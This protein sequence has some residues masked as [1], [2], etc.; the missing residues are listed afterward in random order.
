MALVR[1]NFLKYPGLFWMLL[2]FLACNALF[3]VYSSGEGKITV[4]F[5]SSETSINNFKSL[6]IEFDRYLS[7]YGPYE[8]QPFSS[9]KDFEEHVKDKPNCLLLLSSWHYRHIHKAYALTPILCGH[10]KEGKYQKRILVAGGPVPDIN[11]LRTSRIASASNPEHTISV[12][13]EMLKEKYAGEPFRILTVPKDIDAL[14]S[15]GFGIAG[16][17]LSTGNSLE[18]L[19]TVSPVLCSKMSILAEGEQ[20]LLMVLAAAKGLEQGVDNIS[21]IL[22]DMASDPEGKRKIRMLGL[23]GW[24]RIDAG[25]MKQLES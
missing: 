24:Q 25:D 13:A 7:R 12:L 22:L 10:R 6:K 20:S 14:M 15:V 21:K 2:V 18:E 8:F 23:D 4:Y 17:A 9:R 3:L 11:A 1:Q 19:K 16:F 5:Y